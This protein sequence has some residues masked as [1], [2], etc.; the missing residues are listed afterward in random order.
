MKNCIR[1]RVPRILRLFVSFL[2]TSP[3]NSQTHPAANSTIPS[4]YA[5]W[6]ARRQCP[7]ERPYLPRVRTSYSSDGSTTGGQDGHT[8]PPPRT[9]AGRG[10]RDPQQRPL[11]PPGPI[12]PGASQSGSGKVEAKLHQTR[13]TP[14]SESG[15]VKS[16][17]PQTRPRQMVL[18]LWDSQTEDEQPRPVLPEETAV[19]SQ[20]AEYGPLEELEQALAA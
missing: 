18:A 7:A 8:S 9:L 15:Q 20:P 19:G 12:V 13:P 3:S 16:K 14:Q 1:N 10:A 6:I 2:T 17:S 5:D 11:L 4:L